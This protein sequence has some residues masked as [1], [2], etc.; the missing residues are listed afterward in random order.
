LA[1]ALLAV[2]VA[3]A[4]AGFW[5]G[6]WNADTRSQVG[7]LRSFDFTDWHSPALMALWRP[8]YDLGFGPGW[9]VALT[10]AVVAVSSYTIFRLSWERV[11]AALAAAATLAY[12]PVLGVLGVVGRDAWF[13]ALVLGC[14]AC[15]AR[16]SARPPGRARTA[17]LA[18]AAVACVLAVA[19]RQN[20]LVIV[21]VVA[22]AVVWLYR[23]DRPRASTRSAGARAAGTL[24]AA[25]LML[26]GVVAVQRAV[27][28]ALDVASWHPEQGAMLYDLFQL[29]EREHEL[30]LDPSY[31]PGQDLAA[32]EEAAEP[33]RYNSV[34]APLIQT[35]G[36]FWYPVVGTSYER[37][38][39]DW[40][41]AIADH[42]TSWLSVRWELYRRVIGIS[43]PPAGAFH[44][45]VIDNPPSSRPSLSSAPT[46]WMMKYL[47]RFTPSAR[48]D[49]GPLHRA[50]PYL[51]VT[52][53]AVVRLAARHEHRTRALLA[54]LGV[55]SLLYNLAWFFVAME[56]QYRFVYPNVVLAVVIVISWAGLARRDH[57]GRRLE[58]S[59][60][61]AGDELAASEATTDD[62]AGHHEVPAERRT[63]HFGAVRP[64]ARARPSA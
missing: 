38:R 48:P 11:P 19:A 24:A 1:Y 35:P 60:V 15:L 53:V 59:E 50:W 13:V 25:S 45:Y 4:V 17:W 54:L 31:Y 52:A 20:G 5:P 58:A 9:L 41:D 55:A 8:W 32:L 44:P 39:S 61:A 34:L 49:G 57:Q 27:Y 22:A 29:S 40:L 6:Y 63:G 64:R 16:G 33:F 7:E 42:P 51:L 47:G 14:W 46:R 21:P 12:A 23:L 43:G 62:A 2:A 30:L 10:I 18:A 3:V 26:V 37:L 28:V 36:N 56:D